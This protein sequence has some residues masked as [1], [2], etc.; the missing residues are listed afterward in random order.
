MNEV[1][2]TERESKLM[3]IRKRETEREREQSER[4]ENKEITR[5]R[6]E[7]DEIVEALKAAVIPFLLFSQISQ[8]KTKTNSRSLKA[9]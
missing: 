1:G 9:V 4:T 6:E 8:K 7:R 5:K 3:G 2:E